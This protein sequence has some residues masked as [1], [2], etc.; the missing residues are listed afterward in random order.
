MFAVKSRP[1]SHMRH[2]SHARITAVHSQTRSLY[3]GNNHTR[4]VRFLGEKKKHVQVT[5]RSLEL[6]LKSETS[7]PYRPPAVSLQKKTRI[8]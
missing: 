5:N 2:P 6:D 7:R 8:L 1:P 3:V 4:D